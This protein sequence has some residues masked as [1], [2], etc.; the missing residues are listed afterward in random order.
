MLPEGVVEATAYGAPPF[1]PAAYVAIFG[2]RLRPDVTQVL[3]DG[4]G[5][6]V[7]YSSTAQINIQLP[8]DIAPG[9][10]ELLLNAAGAHSYPYRFEVAMT[11]APSP[12]SNDVHTSATPPTPNPPGIDCQGLSL[13]PPA[14]LP[15]L[16]LSAPPKPNPPARSAFTNG[17]ASP[18]RRNRPLT[19]ARERTTALGLGL[20]RFYVGPRFDYVHPYLSPRRFEGDEAGARTPAEILQIPRY[21]A[22]LD[23][24]ALRTVI[25]TV[26]AQWT[27]AGPGRPEPSAS[28]G[29]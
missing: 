29:R 3:I 13:R 19:A 6:P 10:H 1:A 23:D 21:A 24:P 11:C 20:L 26:Y 7:A 28:L 8:A 18:C 4:V 12:V 17:S 9:P 25:L 15:R 2:E 22:V 16:C 5:I 27:M 14:W